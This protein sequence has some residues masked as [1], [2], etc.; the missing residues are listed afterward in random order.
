MSR[1][2]T[3]CPRAQS[4]VAQAHEVLVL[5]RVHELG[6]AARGRHDARR[7]R[8][9]RRHGLG[10]PHLPARAEVAVSVFAASGRPTDL[11]ARDVLAR[12]V[13]VDRRHG[14]DHEEPSSVEQHLHRAGTADPAGREAGGDGVSAVERPR[15][16]RP[17]GW[18]D[19]RGV[20]AHGRGLRQPRSQAQRDDP[21]VARAL[22]GRLGR[23]A[24]EVLR[25]SRA[26]DGA[27]PGDGRADP[28]RRAHRRRARSAPPGTATAGSAT[29]T[30]GT[31][32]CTT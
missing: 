16:A 14:I 21:G 3:P 20:R 9:P 27:A 11:G 12:L 1:G 13:G 31:T 6:R 15:L 7:C 2:G 25:H 28:Q 19:A 4:R 30:R 29:P 17:R 18:L 26:H 24:R 32:R 5:H 10:P 8:L 22:E 23:V